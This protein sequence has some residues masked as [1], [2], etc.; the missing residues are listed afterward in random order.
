[1]G[2]PAGPPL[3]HGVGGAVGLLAAVAAA[4]AAAVGAVGEAVREGAVAVEAPA[5]GA[6][7]EAVRGEGVAATGFLPVTKRTKAEP[8]GGRRTAAISGATSGVR[9][10]GTHP[11]GEGAADHPEGEASVE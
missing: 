10:G 11:L 9:S 5:A 1:M 2:R 7:G 4:A 3:L 8:P 6:I